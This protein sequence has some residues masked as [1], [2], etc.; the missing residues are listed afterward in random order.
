[1]KNFGESKFAARL[2]EIVSR[3]REEAGLYQ[4]IAKQLPF[5]AKQRILDVGT[6]TGLQLK[7]IHAIHPEADL[8]GLD[9]SRAA[10]RIASQALA[11]L[12]VDLRAGS[13]LSTSYENDFFDVVTCNS[14]MSYWEKPGEC[15]NEIFRIVKNG[16]HVYLFE[17]HREIEIEKAL[18]QIRKKMAD[19]NPLRR[20]GAVQMNKF[21]L[22]RGSRLG[23]NLYA[24]SELKEIAR[25]SLFADNQ[26]ITETSLLGIP[27]FVKIHLWKG[28]KTD[29]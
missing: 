5:G 21:A 22:T 26:D 12:D 1:M 3:R 6:G 8:F 27:I 9:L 7:V 10:I 20:W 18:D 19:K 13:I 29:E 11:G 16:G 2:Q 15:F 25:G 28:E 24:I 4:E 23:M 14:S 17:P